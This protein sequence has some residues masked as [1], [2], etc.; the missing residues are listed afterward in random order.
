VYKMCEIN[1]AICFLV[2][3]YLSWIDIRKRQIPVLV[4]AAAGGLAVLYQIIGGC[5][6]IES[7]VTGAVPGMFFLLVSKVTEESMGYGDSL[8]ILILG[9]YLGFWQIL[10]VLCSAFFLM[11]C[12]LIPVLWKNKMSRKTGLAFYPFLTGGYLLGTIIGG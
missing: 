12:L 10:E 11:F 5:A 4:L 9:M 3:I 1:K 6:N 7:V 2:L 8:G